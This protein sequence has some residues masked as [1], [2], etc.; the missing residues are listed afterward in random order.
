MG[1]FDSTMVPCPACGKPVEFQSKEWNCNMDVWQL[2][3]A[4]T[5]VLRDIMNYPEYC[6][7][8]GAWFALVDP[9]YPPGPPPR[10]KL[11]AAIV[12][13]PSDALVHST[14]PFLRWWPDG[15]PFTYDDLVE[16]VS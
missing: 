16:P 9:D 5:A 15:R 3:E 4:P 11:R 14:Q 6:R 7:H 2:D 12:K 10:P 13:T 1:M 8:C